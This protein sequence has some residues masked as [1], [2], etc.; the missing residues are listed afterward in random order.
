MT[1]VKWAFLHIADLRLAVP[2][3]QTLLWLSPRAW[4]GAD[5]LEEASC[6]SNK[7]NTLKAALKVIQ[8]TNLG[9]CNGFLIFL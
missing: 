2:S 5:V 8:D 4:E 7:N 1:A 6:C 9:S 3:E